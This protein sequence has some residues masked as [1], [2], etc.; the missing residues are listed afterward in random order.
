K[1][2]LLMWFFIGL[3]FFFNYKSN[4]SSSDLYINQ[5]VRNIKLLLTEK[6]NIL[7]LITLSTEAL[8]NSSRLVTKEEWSSF[9][10]TF[11][12]NSEFQMIK[13]Q[14]MSLY[15]AQ[16]K[17]KNFVSVNDP[18]ISEVKIHQLLEMN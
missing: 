11:N 16:G 13:I 4:H 1:P 2:L 12:S 14:A 8:V 5:K 10:K 18:N 17:A 6:I 3:I 9:E 7:K 15:D